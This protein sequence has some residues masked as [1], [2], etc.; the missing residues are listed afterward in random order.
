MSQGVDSCH[1]RKIKQFG[2]FFPAKKP[3]HPGPP[4]AGGDLVCVGNGDQ[5]SIYATAVCIASRDLEVP[6]E[7]QAENAANRDIEPPEFV[8]DGLAK[9]RKSKR[10]NSSH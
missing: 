3:I 6:I 7:N 10:L 9:D 5:E 2:R 4:G 1:P 8:A